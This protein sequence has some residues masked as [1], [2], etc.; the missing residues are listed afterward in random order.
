MMP[1]DDVMLSDAEQ[2]RVSGHMQ[3]LIILVQND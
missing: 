1:L 2:Q 3:E